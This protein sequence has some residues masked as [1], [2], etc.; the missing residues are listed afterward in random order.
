M[1][2]YKYIFIL[3]LL[4]LSMCDISASGDFS[5]AITG[6][7]NALFAEL[8]RLSGKI[9]DYEGKPIV[10][11]VI[12]ISSIDKSTNSNDR[13]FF[14]ITGITPGRYTIDIF[15]SGYMD[16]KSELI[17]MTNRDKH[18]VFKLFKKMSEEIVVTATNSPKLYEEVPVKVEIVTEK[19]IVQKQA[20][21]LAESLSLTSGVRVENDCQNC[22]FTQV[23]IN[24]LDGKYSQILIDNSPVFSPMI[25]V[26][27]LEQI[28][29]EILSRI[30][31]VKGGGSVLYGGNAIAGVINV[32]TKEPEF[33]RTRINYHQEWISGEPYQNVGIQNSFINDLSTTKTHIFAN[34]KNRKAVDLDGDGFSEIGEMNTCSFGLNF[35]QDILGSSGKLKLSFFH[36]NEDRRGGDNLDQP[37]HD[38]E[39]AEWIKSNLTG[40]SS[41]WI[42]YIS[43]KINY[44]VDMS[45]LIAD[46]DTYYGSGKDP[47]AY[48]STENPNFNLSSQFNYSIGSNTISLGAQY[49]YE[50]IKDIALVYDRTIDDTYEEIGVYL[51]DDLK[52]NDDI[53]ILAGIRV[54]DHS[55][56]ESLIFNPRLSFLINLSKDL[57]WRTSFSSG[58]RAPQIFD[59]D[60]HITQVGGEG[61]VIVNSPDLSEEKSYSASSGLDYGIAIGISTVKL[62]LEGFYTI[63]EDTFILDEQ[64]DDQSENRRL[65]QRINGSNAEVYGIGA[66]FS[67]QMFRDLSIGGGW[68][69]QKSRLEEP[70]SDFGSTDIFKTPDTYG[71]F[72]L[73]Y[74]NEDL[75]SIV[76]SLEYTGSMKVPHYSGYIEEDVLETTEPFWVF[77]A[78]INHRFNFSDGLELVINLGAYN[79][80][81]DYQDDLDKGPNRDSGYVYGP[82]KPR[83]YYSSLELSF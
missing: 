17:D 61:M 42:H 30:E 48:G 45:A 8:R 40:I 10:N 29:A 75:F 57:S 15:A 68:T 2:N 31:I 24:G 32:M 19:E 47:N 73:N 56:I 52:L 43:P 5:T 41:R 37:P 53:F 39:I 74:D 51:Q 83:S 49:K 62:S 25:G 34:Y 21:N 82:S 76:L 55:K 38:A 7:N 22:N 44:H 80:F 50:H 16:F 33:S 60:L 77:N 67:L 69:F 27:G 54:T 9:T 64:E 12:L 72:T 78:K 4:S 36:I 65:F 20:K 35:Y 23:R 71:Y 13:G 59:E 3:L 63:I 14:E 79:L 81:N 28:P 11:A 46:R 58:F 26:Y 18:M 6:T 70:E 1:S 66:D